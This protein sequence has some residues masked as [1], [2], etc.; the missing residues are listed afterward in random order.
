MARNGK[1]L[2]HSDADPVRVNVDAAARRRVIGLGILTSVA[3][4]AVLY[5]L[6]SSSSAPDP[7]GEPAVAE[8]MDEADVIELPVPAD[9]PRVTARPAGARAAVPHAE[10]PPAGQEMADPEPEVLAGDY[11]QA[12]RDARET[13]GLAAFPPPGTDPIKRG[14][15]VPDD[16]EL[17][18]GYA[19]HHQ[20]T[21]DGKDVPAILMFSPGYEFIGADGQPIALPADRIVPPN[22]APPG[23]PLRMLKLGKRRGPY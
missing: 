2:G 15:L 1:P 21:D 13:E 8:N 10:P 11:I 16:Y 9:R 23:L 18:E 14:I 22:L 20:T 17:P 4:V 6:I 7:R 3:G 5:V 19:R 12:L